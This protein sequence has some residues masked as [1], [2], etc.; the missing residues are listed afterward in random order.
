MSRFTKETVGVFYAEHIGK[1]FFPTLEEFMTSDVVIGMELVAA[2][3]IQK[4]RSFIGPT[5]SLKAKAEAP[6]SIRA[7]FGTDGT[8]NAVHGSDST[9][10]ASREIN[11]F[12]DGTR[13]MK[14]SAVLNNCSL[15][16]IKPHIIRNGQAGQ[17][18]DM[19][20][21]SGFEISAAEMFNLNR[22]QIEEFMNVY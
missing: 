20:M 3:A 4:W 7:M 11:F 19:I 2:N 21:Q 10:S 14:T 5:N 12:F 1:P 17:V 13:N 16:I 6:N 9:A 15:C 18:V 22:P 8:K